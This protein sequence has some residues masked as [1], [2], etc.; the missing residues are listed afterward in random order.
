MPEYSRL[1]SLARP[2]HVN[3]SMG[4]EEGGGWG[5]GGGGGDVLVSVAISSYLQVVSN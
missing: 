4:D 1:V 5:G 3:A 2:Y